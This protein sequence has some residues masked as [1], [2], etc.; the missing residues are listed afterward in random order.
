ME[1]REIL[2]GL[3]E[4]NNPFLA[5]HTDTDGACCISGRRFSMSKQLINGGFCGNF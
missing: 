3:R 2:K 1:I 5:N 4:K